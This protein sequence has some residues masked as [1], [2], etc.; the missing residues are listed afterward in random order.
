MDKH[1]V[2]PKFYGE[3]LTLIEVHERL[4]EAVKQKKLEAKQK[5]Q[6][7]AKLLPRPAKERKKAVAASSKGSKAKKQPISAQPPTHSPVAV[8]QVRL[9]IQRKMM[10]CAKNVLLPTRMTIRR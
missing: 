9:S 7:E 6:E 10:G 3:A 8:T 2:R 4:L 5:N 1:K